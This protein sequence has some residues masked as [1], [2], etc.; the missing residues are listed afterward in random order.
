MFNSNKYDLIVNQGEQVFDLNPELADRDD[1]RFWFIDRKTLVPTKPGD[2]IVVDTVIGDKF[3]R[4]DSKKGIG[5]AA[6]FLGMFKEDEEDSVELRKMFVDTVSE[7]G[8][9]PE[10]VEEISRHPYFRAHF[11][12]IGE[13]TFAG[14]ECYW[15]PNTQQRSEPK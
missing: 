9:S 8:L 5:I 3:G 12:G 6:T 13:I 11:D 2:I 1:S 10:Q 15:I 7:P 4:Y 14:I